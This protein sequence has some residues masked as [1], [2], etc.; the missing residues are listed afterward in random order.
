MELKRKVYSRGWCFGGDF[1]SITSR[2]ERRG[3]DGSYK[4]GEIIDFRYFIEENELIKVPCLGSKFS[5]FN[6]ACTSMSILDRFLLSYN[7]ISIWKVVGQYVGQRDMSNQCLIWL[8]VSDLNWGP[9]PFKFN[10]C[11]LDHGELVSF[12][13]DEW[14]YFDVKGRGN[15]VKKEKLKRFKSMLRWWNKE[16]FCWIDLKVEDSVKEMNELE[17][18]LTEDNGDL[19]SDL[20]KRKALDSKEI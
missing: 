14:K 5:W 15:F 7:L 19:F 12:V 6:S 4:G 8:K 11:W 13:D 16:V 10:R 17:N 18:L 3:L 1:N 2:E 20:V 9:K